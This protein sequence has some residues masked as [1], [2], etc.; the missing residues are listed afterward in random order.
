ME[1][2]YRA[3]R[4][5]T[6]QLMKEQPGWTVQR[7]SSTISARRLNSYAWTHGTPLL[8]HNE[9]SQEFVPQVDQF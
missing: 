3:D 5:H 6:R 9:R 4:A 1:E 2:E 8:H 7:F